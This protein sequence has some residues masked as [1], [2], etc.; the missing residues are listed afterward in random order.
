MAARERV[1]AEVSPSPGIYIFGDPDRPPY[2]LGSAVDLR[3]RYWQLRRNT[4]VLKHLKIGHDANRFRYLSLW[5]DPHSRRPPLG[6]ELT[7]LRG[8]KEHRLS[9]AKNGKN[10]TTRPYLTEWVDLDLAPLVRKVSENPMI[11]GYAVIDPISIIP[12]PASPNHWSHRR[13]LPEIRAVRMSVAELALLDR[14]IAEQ[15]PD[16]TR[17]EALRHAFKEWMEGR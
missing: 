3:R 14:F 1:S 16:M 12:N 15:Q 13:D 2:K 7:L 9:L 10:G 11:A 5:A 4:E 6:L 8:L 17:P